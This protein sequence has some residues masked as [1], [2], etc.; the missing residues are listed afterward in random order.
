[1]KTANHALFRLNN[2]STQ[3]L[4]AS[5][6]MF[7]RQGWATATNIYGADLGV[8]TIPPGGRHHFQDVGP[9]R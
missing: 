3:R 2:D 4:S 8:L 1:M 7:V 6:R 9:E 5:G